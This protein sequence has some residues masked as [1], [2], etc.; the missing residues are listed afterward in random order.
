MK[1]FATLAT[2]LGVA[3]ANPQQLVYTGAYQGHPIAGQPLVYTVQAVAPVAPAAAAP[4]P[5]VATPAIQRPTAP[6]VQRP[7]AA[8]K[9]A[10]YKGQNIDEARATGV[11]KQYHKQDEFGN[12]AYGYVNQN[13]EK[14]EAGN[15]RLGVKG[16]YTY[17]DGNGLNRRV[18][19]VADNQGY[20]ASGDDVKPVKRSAD[21]DIIMTSSIMTDNPQDLRGLVYNNIGQLPTRSI[22][23]MMDDSGLLLSSDRL[24]DM[25][26]LGMETLM[27]RDGRLGMSR[28]GMLDSDNMRLRQDLTSYGNLDQTDLGLGGGQGRVLSR[29]DSLSDNMMVIQR[30]AGIP[31][32]RNSFRFLH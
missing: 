8:I 2:V 16:H 1:F 23:Y 18:D 32:M 10:T 21:A 9:P 24:M 6:V 13:S 3:A 7:E 4:R 25:S 5:I 26:R 30:E 29:Q 28:S 11:S 27:S 14:H 19:Y 20:R 31:Q 12:Y 17:V 22:M 15:S